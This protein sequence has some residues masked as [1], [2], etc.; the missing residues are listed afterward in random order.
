MKSMKKAALFTAALLSAALLA[1]GQNPVHAASQVPAAKSQVQTEQTAQPA[2]KKTVNKVAK[3]SS[4]KTTKKAVKKHKSVKRH[5]TKYQPYADPTDMRKRK[6]NWW[7]YSSETK[8][9]Y[10]NLKK[11]KNLNLRVS[12]KGNRVYVRSGKKVLYTMYCSA[13]M[14]RGGHS[15]TPRGTFY[16]N[17]YKPYRFDY[18]YYPVGWRGQLYLFHSTTTYLWSKRFNLTEA[19][20]LGKKP[21]SHGCIRLTVKDARWLH[22]HVPYHTKVIIRYR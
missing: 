12:I 7:K 22:Y 2:Q 8:R 4:K 9:K 10:P 1:A 14:I 15:L 6:G 5:K 19:H 20:K 16:T 18:A 21:A 13:G 17:H 11:V 3:T